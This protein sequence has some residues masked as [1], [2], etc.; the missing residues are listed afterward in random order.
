MIIKSTKNIWTPNRNWGNPKY[1]K[2][3]LHPVGFWKAAG[4]APGT[5]T[6]TNANIT[7]TADPPGTNANARYGLSVSTGNVYEYK[8]ASVSPSFPSAYTQINS[9]ND[10]I[11]PTTAD[12]GNFEVRVQLG[13]GTIIEF[14]QINGVGKTIGTTWYA[15][16]GDLVLGNYRTDLEG[17]GITAGTA[18]V[19]IRYDGGEILDSANIQLN[20][21]IDL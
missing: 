19:A 13:S 20:A 10:W 18:D 11:R 3:I 14:Y 6:L 1:Q 5:V 21:A 4:G 16:D 2:G 9:T 12:D 8:G 15:L 17:F 7:Y